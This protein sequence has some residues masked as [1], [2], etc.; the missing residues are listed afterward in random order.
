M[1]PA[2]TAD[3]RSATPRARKEIDAGDATSRAARSSGAARPKRRSR[4]RSRA[5]LNTPGH[6]VLNFLVLSREEGEGG[7]RE[8]GL[9][10]TLLALNGALYLAFAVYA[11]AVWA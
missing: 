7:G 8:A 1:G 9:G 10:R 11:A 6:A 3:R 5:P 4:R 2:G